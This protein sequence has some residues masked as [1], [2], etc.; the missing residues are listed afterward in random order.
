MADHHFKTQGGASENVNHLA[1][2]KNTA[3]LDIDS[4]VNTIGR[5]TQPGHDRDYF[6]THEP[7]FRRA[8][9]RITEIAPVG[10]CVLDL[11]SHYL[12]L[13]GTLR[14]LGYDVVALDV[15]VFQNLR[16]VRARAEALGIRTAITEAA[17]AGEFL[18]DYD[19]RFDLVLFCEMLEH[20]TFNPC[21]F[22]RRIHGL[23]K[24]GGKVYLSTPN[25]LQA[26]SIIS[27][28]KRLVLL[29]GI[30][31]NIPTIFG[32]VT[33]G[34]H[35]KE[36][37]RREIF[38]Y[39]RILSPDFYVELSTYSYQRHP[40]SPWSL[41]DYSRRVIRSVGN[42]SGVFAEELEAVVTL[43]SKTGIIPSAPSFG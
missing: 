5:S 10:S 18:L 30:G 22:W 15:P 24:I 1:I 11:G 27:A 43:R 4:A 41:K 34:H 28:I 8:A 25:S 40:Y 6:H 16:F 42:W 3:L 20:I 26:L 36:Y 19:D 32:T 2:T 23:I 7:R 35:W 31:T 33:Y 21:E 17:A 9:R 39:F 12:H 38:K 14:L 37:S 13:A 29:D